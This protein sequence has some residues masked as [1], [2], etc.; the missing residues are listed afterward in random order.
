MMNTQ[1]TQR[2]KWQQKRMRNGEVMTLNVNQRYEDG[3]QGAKT[4][5][6][7]LPSMYKNKQISLVVKNKQSLKLEEINKI[8]IN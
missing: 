4:K 1:A 8:K 3:T 5:S 7:N 2:N 6:K